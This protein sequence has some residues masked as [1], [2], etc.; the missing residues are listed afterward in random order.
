MPEIIP[1]SSMPVSYTHLDVYKRQDEGLVSNIYTVFEVKDENE[2]LPEY[3]M[4]WFSRPE[5]EDVYKRQGFHMGNP[6]IF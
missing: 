5:F 2:L 4:L 1:A 3:L 6:M